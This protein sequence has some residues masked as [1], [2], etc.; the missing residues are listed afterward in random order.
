[1]KREEFIEI[2]GGIFENNSYY[3]KWGASE[4][5]E[6]FWDFFKLNDDRFPY[7]KSV[8]AGIEIDELLSKKLHSIEHIFPKGQMKEYLKSKNIKD[9]IIK[10][11]TT[12][13]LNFAPAHRE[14]NSYRGHLPFDIEYEEFDGKINAKIIRKVRLQFEPNYNYWGRDHEDEW[15]VPPISRGNV[16]R[17]MLY[18]CLIYNIKELYQEHINVYKNWCKID[19]PNAV[20]IEYNKWVHEKHGINN[21]FITTD[22]NNMINLLN[23][24]ELLNSILLEN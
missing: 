18:M 2:A 5:R 8:Y 3:K 4:K 17:A 13:P 22:Y 24:E 20:E 12:N 19:P 9:T 16:A 1:M 15:L 7:I 10:G 6:N 11:A 23:D 21:P 14:I